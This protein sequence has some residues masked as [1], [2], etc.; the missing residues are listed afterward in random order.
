LKEHYLGFFLLV[1]FGLSGCGYHSLNTSSSKKISAGKTIS[2]PL[3]ANK[4]YK[5][6]LESVF[7]NAI[8]E[9]F[10]KRR[11]LQIT[12]AAAAEMTLS[13]EV[14]SYI[15]TA[16]SYSRSDTVMQY[17]SS[18]KLNATLRRNSN[19]QVLWKGDL[20]WD[21]TYPANVNIGLQ[22]NAE[23]SAIQ[24]ICRRIAQQLYLKIVQDF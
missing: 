5:S 19:Q 15:S 22:Q 3:F 21:Q 4:T 6:N 1:L 2:I 20:S 18:M 7:A 13:G 12:D 23:D 8:I 24:E 11:G 16:S 14:F 9:E 17:S 10:A